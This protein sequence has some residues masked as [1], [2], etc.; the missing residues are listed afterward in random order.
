[1]TFRCLAWSAGFYAFAACWQSSRLSRS[2]WTLVVFAGIAVCMVRFRRGSP[3]F[4]PALRLTGTM[5]GQ[6]LPV[7]RGGVL[8]FSTRQFGIPGPFWHPA[9][10]PDR[11]LK[12]T[13]AGPHLKNRDE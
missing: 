3:G 5:L 11:H 4:M 12:L 10:A 2:L 9:H 13:G 7:G 8:H 6:A 1:M